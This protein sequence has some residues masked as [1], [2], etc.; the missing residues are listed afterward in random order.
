MARNVEED[1]GAYR[2]LMTLG[3][4]TVPVTVIGGQIIRGYDPT[5]L[6]LALAAAGGESSPDR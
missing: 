4:H 1:E 2:D 3:I 6:R 5:Q